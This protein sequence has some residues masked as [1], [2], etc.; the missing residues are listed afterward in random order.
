MGHG[1]GLAQNVQ[2]VEL[3]PTQIELDRAPGVRGN[4]V[5]QIIG[6]L[7]RRQVVY[8]VVELVS[9]APDGAAIGINGLGLQALELEV[10]KALKVIW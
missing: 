4:Q 10:L 3:E 7:R 2:G 1:P 8:A 5:A 9:H 6:Q